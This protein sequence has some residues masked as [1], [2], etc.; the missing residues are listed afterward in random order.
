MFTPAAK[1]ISQCLVKGRGRKL[2]L[3]TTAVPGRL[4]FSV[5]LLQLRLN[6]ILKKQ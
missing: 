4:P 6:L 3:M 2:V 1:N 5:N